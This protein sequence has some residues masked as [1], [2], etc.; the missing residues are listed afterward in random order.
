MVAI[1]Q[2]PERYPALPIQHGMVLNSLR[3]PE[4]GVDVLQVTLD[5]ADPLVPEPFE[6]AWHEVAR[7]NPVLRTGFELHEEYGLVQVVDP[8]C[9]IDIRWRELAAAPATGDDAEFEEFLRA[10]RREPFDLTR[11][12]LLRLSILRRV[13]AGQ[14][15]A[16]RHSPDALPAYRA[17]LTF[18]HAL[19]DG[20]SMRLLVD[21]VCQAYAAKLA[22]QAIALPSRPPFCDFVRW[23]QLAD[24]SE[25][26]KFWTPY[27]ADA[28]LP[29]GLPGYLGADRLGPAEP[30][31]LEAV[32]SGADSER[33][34]EASRLAG[35]SS[36]TMLSAAWALLRAR[37]GG[38]SDVVLAVTRSCRHA[39]I[40]DA[41]DV[42]GV[43]I[44]TV[45]LRVRIDPEW[46]V[47]E[48]LA[49]VDSGIAGVREHQR[50]PMASIL[51]WAGLPVDTAL[52]D[53]LLMYDRCRLQTRLAAGPA[54]PVSARVDRLPSFPLT[55]CGYGE[56]QLH[57]GMIWDGRRFADGSVEQM[58][59]QLRS[60]L[61]EF[62][63][64]PSRRR[65]T[66]VLRRSQRM[67]PCMGRVAPS[68][69]R[70]LVRAAAQHRMMVAAP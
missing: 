50:T 53:S 46:T 13:P 42:M 55:V 57:L 43:L 33:I 15:A 1:A 18:H 11:P 44:N 70:T 17:V 25:S 21:E 28:V 66:Q 9:S 2:F 19:L 31:R 63:T 22:G 35:L 27:L 41:D 8:A 32:L 60:T 51:T 65:P 47:T 68:C 6:A 3:Y 38:V 45:P 59:R 4:D 5:W 23:W 67:Y 39:S 29:R 7:H 24:E 58:L 20:R 10:D 26:E 16:G 34:S 49:A 48:L 54:R 52:I 69:G 40:P 56:T 30:R 12:P 62:A 61:I 64:A 14:P 37:Y 36:S